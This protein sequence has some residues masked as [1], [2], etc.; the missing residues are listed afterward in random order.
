MKFTSMGDAA[1]LASVTA[2]LRRAF[3]E[4]RIT[5]AT[6]AEYRDLFR[7]TVGADFIVSSA[8]GRGTG[9][10]ALLHEILRSGAR[11][12][13]DMEDSAATRFLRPLL[14]LSGIRVAVAENCSGRLHEMTR[15]SRKV[16][17]P[18]PHITE[19]YRD[20]LRR[21]EFE[22]PLVCR[23]P[24]AAIPLPPAVAA[25]TGPKQGVW[26][27]VAP[28]AKHKGKIYPIPL[29]DRLIGML[30]SRYEK[31]FILGGGTHERSFAEGMETRHEG[32]VSLIGRL[33]LAQEM[34]LLSCL[35]AVV[36]MDSAS[37][38]IASLVGTPVVSV[39]GATH[40]AMG[41]YGYCQDPDDAVQLDLECRPCSTDGGRRCIFGDYRCLTGISPRRILDAVERTV[42]RRGD[43]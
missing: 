29:T 18:L 38:H 26:I 43:R 33:P 42:A 16:R 20:T 39:W 40:P 14:R 30:N 9:W 19:R 37:N 4:M 32:V 11:Y 1:L 5:V 13:A 36:S 2:S 28:F 21:L 15:R 7:D 12:V 34:D 8:G 25:V 23:T 10:F 22:F 31:V 27:G 41:S 6:K 35:D 24:R 3:P 17:T